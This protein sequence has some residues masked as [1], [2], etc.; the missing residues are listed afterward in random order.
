MSVW[1]LA[2]SGL[3]LASSFWAGRRA[4]DR[5]RS[6]KRALHELRGALEQMAGEIAFAAPPF[7]SLCRRAGQGREATTARYFAL[8]AEEAERP[9][10]LPE[11]C[12][13]RA[14]AGSGLRLPR[15]AE[16]ALERLFDGFGQFD[17][18]TQ[19]RRIGLT[20]ETLQRCEN[21]LEAEL[22][23]RCRCLELLGLSAGAALLLVV[24]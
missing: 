17:R 21:A 3:I 4:A 5:L 16:S 24:I 7:A 20:A 1:K 15:D 13:A 22:E 6:D 2:G 18:E 19:L 10:F 23:G 8:L 11:G 12:S 14:A 9:G